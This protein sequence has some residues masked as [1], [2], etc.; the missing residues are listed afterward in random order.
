LQLQQTSKKI[1]RK[2]GPR[3]EYREIHSLLK[4]QW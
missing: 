3:T 1:V 4:T 2:F